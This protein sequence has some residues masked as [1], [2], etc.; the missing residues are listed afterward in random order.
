MSRQIIG[1]IL[2]FYGLLQCNCIYFVA[3]NV[4]T[5][6]LNIQ[7]SRH[8]M[9]LGEY[10]SD[11]NG[12]LNGYIAED[13]NN[14]VRI[15][16]PGVLVNRTNK[17]LTLYLKADTNGYVMYNDSNQ[18]VAAFFDESI[19]YGPS[20]LSIPFKEAYSY[21]DQFNTRS[22]GRMGA[23]FINIDSVPLKGA[24][25]LYLNEF[26]P[27]YMTAKLLKRAYSDK[28]FKSNDSISNILFTNLTKSTF[29]LKDSLIDIQY[30][31]SQ[32][33]LKLEYVQRNRMALITLK[34]LLP[35]IYV[36]ETPFN[37]VEIIIAV[38]AIS[39]FGKNW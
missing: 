1:Y 24:Q 8:E 28:R 37:L 11:I 27:N 35:I 33:P 12:I 36:I 38:S 16:F 17:V 21:F 34:V 26:S 6:I 13:G 9:N 29:E 3:K 2:G 18:F 10:N 15:Q 5:N 25:Y 7:R 30:S 31:C 19:N 20:S 39:K 14:F 22:G 23:Q 4:Q 32:I